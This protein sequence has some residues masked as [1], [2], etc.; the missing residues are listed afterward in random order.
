MVVTQKNRLLGIKTELGPDALLLKSFSLQEQLGRL[1]QIE[2]ELLSEK[3][4][5]SFD[6]LVGTK[7]TIRLATPSGD[8]RFFHGYI[9]R[10]VQ[11]GNDGSFATYRATLVPWLWFLTRSADCRIFQNKKAP[12]IIEQI[13]KDLGFSDYKLK[14]SA[15]YRVWEYC[16]QYR[17]TDFNFV[18]RLMEQE[19][20]YYYF[21]HIEGVH[22]LILIDALAAHDPY[23][24]YEKLVYRPATQGQEEH[25]ETVTDWVIEREVQPGKWALA[26]FN[27]KT[28]ST[29]LMV[30]AFVQRAHQ[31]A[32]LEIYDYPGEYATR[33]EGDAYAK[34]RIQEVQSQHEILRGQSTARGLAAGFKF[35]LENHFRSDQNRAY[36]VT[37]T[38][39]QAATGAYNSTGE[40]GGE[41]F[42]CGFTAA[43]A[44]EPFRA[45][46]SSPKPHI[47]G[48]QTAIVVGRAGEEIDPDEFGRVKVQFH[49]D[50]EGKKDE[51]SSCWVRVSQA[52]AGKNWG[53]I[54]TPRI[55][56]EVIV[57]FLEGD[58][59][60]PIITGRVYN[61]ANKVPYPLPAN[62]NISTLK[63][64]STKGGGGFNEMKF[65]DTKGKEL[66]YVQAEKDRTVLV[67]NDNTENVGH[68]ETIGIGNDRKKDVAKNETTTIGDN[69][70]E[71]VGKDETISIKGNRTETVTKDEKI[72][73]NGNRTEVVAKEEN[74]TINGGR[75]ETVAKDEKIT[76]SGGRTESVAKDEKITISGGRT[77]SVSKDESI[78]ISGGRTESVSK[79]ETVTITGDRTHDVGKNDT[80]KVGKA[81]LVTAG[82]QITLK[83]GDASIVM[84]KDG[85]IQI[86]GKDITIDGSGAINVKASKNITMKGQK[87][88]QN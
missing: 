2:T 9:S 71:T 67:K 69:R 31:Q 58:P 40:N 19:G 35:T 29:N 66:V 27:F 48:P 49:W 81:I 22:T 54:Y 79:N 28:P 21:E 16:V 26:D 83:T 63:S 33:Q 12:E 24:G 3:L 68:D 52:W 80:L 45:A 1:F 51:N 60:R 57:E 34:L 41:F 11:T 8:T 56:Q 70:T 10:F 75:T 5:L 77:E 17:E 20:I 61:A 86:K 7:A 32:G 6:A 18:S 14:L 13:F 85:T 44:A 82:D 46:R 43:P 36:L 64:D 50:R 42:S 37:G 65:D 23:P 59:D 76:I 38:S 15:T 73:I 55:G 87:I 30:N 72:T 53:A 39:L 4:D 74:I 88:L 62:K 84:K 47:Q 78:S 25:T